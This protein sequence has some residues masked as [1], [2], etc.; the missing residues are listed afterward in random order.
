MK[1]PDHLLGSE[2]AVLPDRR[3]WT[4]GRETCQMQYLRDVHVDDGTTLRRIT[5]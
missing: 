5:G 3:K 2:G 1:L 4:K